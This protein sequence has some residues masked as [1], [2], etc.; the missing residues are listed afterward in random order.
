M[1]LLT[2]NN[3]YRKFKC[4]VEVEILFPIQW[5]IEIKV[6]LW[7]FSIYFQMGIGLVILG[8]FFLLSIIEPV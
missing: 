3:N 5:G 6:Y 2:K 1:H 7:L 8:L 4:I